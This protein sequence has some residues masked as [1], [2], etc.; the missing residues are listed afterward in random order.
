MGENHMRTAK[1]IQLLIGDLLRRIR[2]LTLWVRPVLDTG[3]RIRL[4][5]VDEFSGH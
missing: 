1:H 2:Q 4:P 3:F 5:G